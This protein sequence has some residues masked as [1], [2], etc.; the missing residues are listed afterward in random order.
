[1]SYA[2]QPVAYVVGGR[3]E[4]FE[5]RWGG[6]R[7]L[8]RMAPHLPDDATLGLA[9]FSHLEV[10]YVFHRVD[11]SK[12]RDDARH[13]RG[14]P[15]WPIV[16]LFTSRGPYRPNRL[17]VSRCRLLEV[18]GRDLHV[19]GLDALD[20]TPVLDVKPHMRE[21]TPPEAVVTQ[22]A[23]ASQLMAHYYD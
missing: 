2:V 18:T 21:F 16:G 9:D 15:Q 12:I 4:W 23:W 6:V 20:G 14:N 7:S 22:P 1:M 19:Q 10:V 8:I 3:D 13:P 11:P 17:G 5:D